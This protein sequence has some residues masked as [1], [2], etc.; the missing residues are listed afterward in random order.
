M[1]NPEGLRFFRL[2][3]EH[4]EALGTFFEANNLPAV[5]SSFNP[6]PM[7]RDA[8]VQ[9]LD[10]S[11]KDY[12]FALECDGALVGFSMLRGYDE[13]FAIPSFG[14][15]I[16]HRH[17]GRKLGTLLTQ[18]TLRWADYLQAPRTR[19]TVYKTNAAGVAVY[20]KLGFKPDADQPE[21]Q[22]KVVMFR[23][24]GLAP[25][26]LFVSTAC[27]PPGERFLERIQQWEDHGLFNIELSAYPD[28]PEDYLEQLSPFSLNIL[29]HNFFPPRP[30][31]PPA[32]AGWPPAWGGPF[33]RGPFFPPAPRSPPRS[34]STSAGSV[35]ASR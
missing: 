32:G 22:E 7:T 14:I 12:F 26:P 5:T 27:L 9:L 10:P 8:A 30:S 34:R 21:D 28:V 11:N 18:W 33:A 15:F 16:D 4:R 1:T 20:Q 2:R 19:L 24:P 31:S 6:F 29:I 25:A 13:G 3:P 35:G 17:Q 23:E